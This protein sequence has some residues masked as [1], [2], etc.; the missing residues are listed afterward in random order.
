MAVISVH[1]DLDRHIDA[2]IA[3]Y[4]RGWHEGARAEVASVFMAILSDLA[5]QLPEGTIRQE[6]ALYDAEAKP[7]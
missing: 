2:I 6:L 4:R 1:V 5:A 7:S 3:I